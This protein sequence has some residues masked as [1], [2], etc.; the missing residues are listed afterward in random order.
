MFV[1]AMKARRHA[2]WLKRRV[3]MPICCDCYTTQPA[4]AHSGDFAAAVAG[5]RM[6]FSEEKNQKTFI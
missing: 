2:K 4:V 3:T 1:A 5:G 6:F